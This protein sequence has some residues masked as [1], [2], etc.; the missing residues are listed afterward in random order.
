MDIRSIGTKL[1]EF[2]KKY[3]YVILV[4]V[5]GIGLM[6]L[7]GGSGEPSSA[8]PTQQNTEA[9]TD[10]TEKLTGILSQIQ[11]AGKVQLVLTLKGG[12]KT[13]FQTNQ[14]TTDG[15]QNS[16]V[17]VETVIISG[18][19]RGESGLVQQILAPEYRG[20]IVVCQGADNAA[21]RLAI[22]EA[23]AN[24]TGLGADRIS[25]LKMK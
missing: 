3:R 22:V 6:A 23:V 2:M 20:A 17:R 24:A 9:F 21:V 12:E 19:D 25:V 14:D 8:E 13:V 16:T 5:I 15:E 1:L 7:P 18:S 4:L 10:P 11:G